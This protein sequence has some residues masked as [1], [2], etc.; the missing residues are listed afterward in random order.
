MR[1]GVHP[2]IVYLNSHLFYLSNQPVSNCSSS[3]SWATGQAVEN[4][5]RFWGLGPVY[6]RHWQVVDDHMW[7]VMDW[8]TTL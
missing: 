3:F 8:H 7:A 1:P 4:Y 6:G 5:R 2:S